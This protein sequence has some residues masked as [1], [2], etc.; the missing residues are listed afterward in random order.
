M[1]PSYL[2][3]VAAAMLPRVRARLASSQILV[4]PGEQAFV[5]IHD[6]GRPPEPVSFTRIPGESCIDAELPQR[7]VHLFRLRDRHVVVRLAVVE[8]CRCCHV[9]H[10]DE[11]RCQSSGY[12]LGGA[13][14]T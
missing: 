10:L 2:R 13:G 11:R 8:Q 4:E 12:L 7:R 3:Q 1:A 6:E 14:A 5:G 9:L